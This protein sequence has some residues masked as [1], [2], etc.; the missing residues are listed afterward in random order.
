MSNK[1]YYAVLGVDK[2]ADQDTIKK[3]YKKLALELHPDRTGGDK[4]AEQRFKEVNEAYSVIGDKD[5]RARHDSFE[6]HQFEWSSWGSSDTEG[7]SMKDFHEIFTNT[8]VS[9]KKSTRGD[10]IGTHVKLT[11]AEAFTGCKKDVTFTY[12]EPCSPCK[13]TGDEPNTIRVSCSGCQGTG[14]KFMRQG[15]IHLRMTC[16]ACGGVGSR[17]SKD[18]S[19]CMGRGTTTANKSV[20]VTIV[21][22]ISDGDRVRLS[23]QGAKGEKSS[24]DA[25]LVVTVL[26]DDTFLREGND[27]I[28]SID[29]NIAEVAIGATKSIKMPD[30]SIENVTFPAGSSHGHEERLKNKGMPKLS[31]AAERGTLK[32]RSKIVVP[33]TLTEE[34]RELLE[35]LAKTLQC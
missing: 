20:T 33:K 5:A 32:V 26:P 2:T 25:Y 7:F 22:G 24:G 31:N 3:A 6:S 12:E 21:P 14:H 16:N 17:R 9:R 13:G 18:C 35:K 28:A 8:H 34:Q 4:A 30:G 10:N 15:F 23:G 29:L 27:L 11:L 19:S 1:D